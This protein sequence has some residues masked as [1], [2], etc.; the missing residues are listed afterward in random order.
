MCFSID[1]DDVL[2]FAKGK[3]AKDDVLPFAKGK[4]AKDNDDENPWT[5]EALVGRLDQLD[6]TVRQSWRRQFASGKGRPPQAT[7]QVVLPFAKGKAAKD[8]DDDEKEET[9]DVEAVR[10]RVLPR[11][12]R[13]KREVEENVEGNSAASADILYRAFQE[14]SAVARRLATLVLELHER[15]EQLEEKQEAWQSGVNDQLRT[16]G[17]SAHKTQALV[18]SWLDKAASVSSATKNVL[19]SAKDDNAS[20]PLSSSAPGH[21]LWWDNLSNLSWEEIVSKPILWCGP[22]LVAL[23]AHFVDSR[24][25]SRVAH[26][27]GVR[28]PWY[29]KV[30]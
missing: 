4:A 22:L 19:P 16:L 23:L 11:L 18:T 2:P 25:G 27:L 9:L 7:G 8:D 20:L 10:K 12:D 29:A 15:R 30:V 14:S 26:T 3:V 17:S 21:P 13:L 1:D 6:K 24:I 28:R 5:V